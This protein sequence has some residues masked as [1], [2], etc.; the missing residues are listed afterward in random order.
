MGECLDTVY[1]DGGCC[2]WNVAMEL[3]VLRELVGE[4]IRGETIVIKI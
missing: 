2:D 1:E 3:E 4:G